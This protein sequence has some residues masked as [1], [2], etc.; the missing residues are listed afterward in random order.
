L[1]W[2]LV[3][4][5]AYPEIVINIG[6]KSGMSLKD[7]IGSYFF[8]DSTF[9]SLG[10]YLYGHKGESEFPIKDINENERTFRV[11][12]TKVR[13]LQHAR[14]PEHI[15]W[16]NYGAKYVV[17]TTGGFV[18]PT[19]PIDAINGSLVGHFQSGAEKIFV[20]APFKIKADPK[21]PIL[22]KTITMIKGI[23]EQDYDKDKHSIISSASC[24]TTC[25]A[26][27]FLPIFNAFREDIATVSMNTIHAATAKQAVLDRVPKAGANDLRILRSIFNNI[28]ITSTGATKALRKVLKGMEKIGFM[29]NSLRIPTS[30][31]SIVTLN[32]DMFC[33]TDAKQI[34]AI[35][36]K[37][38]DDDKNGYLIFNEHQFVS[39]DVIGNPAACIIEA[40][41][42]QVVSY[43]SDGKK[44]STAQVLGWYDNEYGY[45]SMMWE[46]IKYVI[47]MST[48]HM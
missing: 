17:D 33:L 47:K 34:N 42:T 26:H 45:V 5:N 38:A 9:I 32:A 28:I 19:A 18:D 44:L 48:V 8:R 11:N 10:H 21:S 12:G 15:G 35:L 31:G 14:R 46:L 27:L 24:T 20:S 43:N 37:S 7:F 39:S 16:G 22:E 23:N 2:K 30:A 41:E 1:A 36:K 13:I 6:R 4:Q 40:K 29:G 25:L 3:A